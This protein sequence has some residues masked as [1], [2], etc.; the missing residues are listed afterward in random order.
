VPCRLVK[1]QRPAQLLLDVHQYGELVRRFVNYGVK[2]DAYGRVS[3]A[4]SGYWL[5]QIN[6]RNGMSLGDGI[7]Q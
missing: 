2:W 1:N 5:I 3:P 6:A 7:A 4:G